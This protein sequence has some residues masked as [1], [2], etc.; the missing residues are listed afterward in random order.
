MKDLH[1]LQ[2]ALINILFTAV[3]L[4]RVDAGNPQLAE[5]CGCT[6]PCRVGPY[7]SYS[8]PTEDR[9]GCDSA[10]SPAARSTH[11]SATGRANGAPALSTDT[12]QRLCPPCSLPVLPFKASQRSVTLVVL[13]QTGR[14][15][16]NL[17]GRLKVRQMTKRKGKRTNKL[18]GTLAFK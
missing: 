2:S 8:S 6:Q 15:I 14:A 18:K 3:L 12:T 17:K 11:C 9:R 7:S 10:S 16:H 13:G 5:S 1:H 4:G